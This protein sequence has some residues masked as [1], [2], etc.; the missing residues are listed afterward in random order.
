M[1]LFE[2][3]VCFIFNPYSSDCT[4]SVV[5]TKDVFNEKALVIITE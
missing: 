3:K 4:R 2:D 1:Y 5:I